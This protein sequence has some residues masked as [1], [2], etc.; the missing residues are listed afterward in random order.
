MAISS[1]GIGSGLDIGGIISGL[2]EVEKLPL[3]KLDADEVEIHAEI[4]AYGSLKNTLST[5]QSSLVR[6]QDADTFLATSAQSSNEEVFTVSSDSEAVS[7]AY[8]VTVKRLAQRHKLG[9]AEF[10]ASD[11]FGADGDELTITSGGETFTL[12]FAGAMTLA[13]IQ[14]AINVEANTTGLSAG[15]I[16]GDNDKQ[17]LV[18]TSGESGYENRVQLSFSGTIDPEPFNFSTTN[19][20]ADGNLLK[21]DSELDSSLLIDGVAV[22]RSSNSINDAVS[23]LT[24]NLVKQGRALVTISQDP[25]VATD[26]VNE[27]ITAFNDLETQFSLTGGTLS[28]NSVLRRIEARVL[29]ALNTA[30]PGSGAFS[31]ISQLGVTTREGGGLQLDT[32]KLLSAL[33]DNLD[34]VIAFFS[35]SANGFAVRLDELVTGFVETE[36]V[37][38]SMVDTANDRIARIETNRAS[39]ERRLELMEESLRSQFTALDALVAKLS[40]T[41]DFLTSQ[42]SSLSD[43]FLD[44]NS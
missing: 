39:L 4:S 31:Y 43:L 10:A 19:R 36:G 18:L 22:T 40:T 12:V 17:T 41:S 30:Q 20:D 8:D 9:S 7:S 27:F 28:G 29:G 15:L 3:N 42:L 5:L 32:D 37:I 26:A 1:P 14:S 2:M 6:L 21:N 35:E 11:L 38:D 25:S 13:D 34:S 24:L 16:T 44:R 23:G 33:D